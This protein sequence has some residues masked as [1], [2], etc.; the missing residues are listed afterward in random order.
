MDPATTLTFFD[1]WFAVHKSSCGIGRL[2][3]SM[4]R[5][6]DAKTITVTL[7]CPRCTKTI[8]GT[9]MDTDWP[10]VNQLLNPIKQN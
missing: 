8:K 3:T 2:G 10:A 9:F 1:K 7:A 6:N 4:E 5:D